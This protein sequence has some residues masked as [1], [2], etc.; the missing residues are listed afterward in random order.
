MESEKPDTHELPI[1]QKEIMNQVQE[2]MEKEKVME[3]PLQK[4]DLEAH[5]EVNNETEEMPAD[6]NA[7]EIDK[8]TE[9]ITKNKV[10]KNVENKQ[11][12]ETDNEKTDGMSQAMEISHGDQECTESNHIIEGIDVVMVSRT[13]DSEDHSKNKSNQME[14][15]PEKVTEMEVEDI[16]EGRLWSDS[17]SLT[18]SKKGAPVLAEVIAVVE[19]VTAIWKYDTDSAYKV[20]RVKV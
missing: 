9:K 13:M 3:A 19:A 6:D 2:V 15:D 5:D 17:I 1:I 10:F 7:L 11:T 8:A 18:I 4:M 12:I 14:I 20:K 16:I